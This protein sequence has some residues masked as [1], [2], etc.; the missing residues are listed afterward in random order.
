MKYL[1]EFLLPGMSKRLP[2]SLRKFLRREKS[3]IRRTNLNSS[4]GEQKIQEIVKKVHSQY[5]T[6]ATV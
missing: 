5:Q 6:N 4:D 3:R 2:K 1:V